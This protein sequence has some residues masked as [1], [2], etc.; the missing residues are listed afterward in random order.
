MK[1]ILITGTTGFVGSCL[2]RCLVGQGYQIDVIAR[3]TSDTWRIDDLIDYLEV[4][5]VDL[6]DSVAVERAVKLMRPE[7]VF[8]LATYGGFVSQRN[9]GLIVESNLRGTVSLLDSCLQVGCE[10]F[11]NTGSSSEYGKKTGPMK[12]TDL[13][14]PDDAYG[15]AKAAATLLCR[16]EAVKREASVVT[17][18][19]FSP[20]GPRDDPKRLIPYVIKSLLRGERPKLSTPSS[21]RDYIF[22]DDVLDA[23]L[24]VLEADLPPGEILN[25]GS[26]MQHEIGEVVG[27]ITDVISSDIEPEWGVVTSQRPEPDCWVADIGKAASELGWQPATSLEAGLRKTVQWFKENLD[28]YP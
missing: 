13:L 25:I 27:L 22:I 9:A 5:Y 3:A 12:E 18:R 24:N 28:Y 19:L 2:A 7:V 15:V 21:V 4:H 1:R 8:H 26:G 23:Y 14:E 16:L 20:Y 17:L 6:R 10:L 11:I